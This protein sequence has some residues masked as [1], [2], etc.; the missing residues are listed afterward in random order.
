MSPEEMRAI[1]RERQVD[2]M[3]A[4]AYQSDQTKEIHRAKDRERI[5]KKGTMI[6]QNKQRTDCR[7]IDRESIKM[8][9]AKQGK[10]ACKMKD[11]ANHMN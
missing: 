10:N 1:S 5:S 7:K 4:Q 2:K 8:D 9:P 11:N 6:H 3:Q